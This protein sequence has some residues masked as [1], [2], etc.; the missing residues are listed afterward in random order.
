MFF[1]HGDVSCG[2]T[3]GHKSEAEKFSKDFGERGTGV[4]T[5]IEFFRHDFR[6]E[7]CLRRGIAFVKNMRNCAGSEKCEDARQQER[8]SVY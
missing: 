6:K 4:E 8:V 3:V 5:Y 1:H 2:P 7:L